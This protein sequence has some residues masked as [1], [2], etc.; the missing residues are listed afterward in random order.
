[1]LSISIAFNAISTHGACTAVFVAVAAAI[2]MSC[3]SL[4]TLDRI[5]FLAWAGLVS[6]LVASM[7]PKALEISRH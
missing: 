6:I 5:S 7:S 2:V 1:M 3:A 4:R